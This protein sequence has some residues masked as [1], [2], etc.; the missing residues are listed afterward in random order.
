MKALN[1]KTL[2]AQASRWAL[3]FLAAWLIFSLW[4]GCHKD[5][6][7]GNLQGVVDSLEKQTVTLQGQNGQLIAQN[8]EHQVENS[9]QLKS[10]TDTIFDLK[11]ADQRRVKEVQRYARIAQQVTYKDKL[12]T[13]TDTPHVTDTHVG[14]IPPQP[15]D[16][17]LIRIPRP[18]KYVD[19]TMSFAGVVVRAGV[20]V[21]SMKITNKLH[22]RT[23][24]LSSGFLNW[25]R[26]TAVQAINEN[27]AFTT[28]GITSL[29]VKDRVTW[30]HRWGKP[31][32]FAVVSIVAYD[33]LRK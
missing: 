23:V 1:L 2:Y 20:R 13:W 8:D 30:W 33:R 26:Q 25:K 3:P 6:I 7:A 21:D 22:L 27:P 17:N 5:A 16:T 15:A 29:V 32:A 4:N 10:L 31:V 19:S 14:D 28:T 12:A 9:K 18:F 11:K 24:T